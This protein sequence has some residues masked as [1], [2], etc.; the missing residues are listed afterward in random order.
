MPGIAFG[1]AAAPAY[2]FTPE[3][4]GALGDGVMD[5]AAGTA[6]GTDDTS[7]INKAVYAAYQYA[8]TN[9]Y[10]EVVFQP[11][12]YLLSAAAS[13]PSYAN[14]HTLAQIAI[15]SNDGGTTKPIIKLKGSGGAWF[16]GNVSEGQPGTVLMSTDQTGG[17]G[18]PGVYAAGSAGSPAAIIGDDR[19]W[20]VGG[21]TNNIMVVIEDMTIRQLDGSSNS[22]CDL[23]SCLTT[24][25][26]NVTCDVLTAAG[27]LPS[28]PPNH[29][30]ALVMA[31]FRNDVPNV[32]D[33]ISVA[34]AEYGI[35]VSEDCYVPYGV[36][37]YCIVGLAPYGSSVGGGTYFA[38]PAQA[39]YF[40]SF[41]CQ[42]G[43]FAYSAGGAFPAPAAINVA[44]LDYETTGSGT[45][46]SVF[47]IS[48]TG[49]DLYGTVHSFRVD[50]GATGIAYALS[51]DGASNLK[52][53]DNYRA[54]GHIAVQVPAASS[55]TVVT[56]S[57]SN[58]VLRDVLLVVSGGTAVTVSIDGTSTGLSSGTFVVPS[59]KTVGYGA[60]TAAP[61]VTAFAL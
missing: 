55:E 29:T 7:A 58:Q 5:Y 61:T 43:L 15:P 3:A 9:G 32:A 14:S 28:L 21:A 54:T 52:V 17:T 56:D 25:Y 37:E 2:Q 34:G 53:V 19:N 60:Y 44:L 42:F 41:W 27:A 11:K 47:D 13:T 1:G 57:N 18:Y 30:A 12:C 24:Q 39:D 10:A 16:N 48:D 8:L 38:H 33:R 51:I 40:F 49:N 23:G 36:A 26:L 22:W 50:T 31:Q 45:W 20:A 4:Y 46:A 35:I 59:N 6:S